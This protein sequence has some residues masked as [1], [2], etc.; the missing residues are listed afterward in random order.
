MLSQITEIFTQSMMSLLDTLK[1]ITGNYGFAIIVFAG[2]VKL[3]LYYPTQ[4]QYKS[5]KDMQKIQPM[6][7]KLQEKYKNDAQKLQLEQMALFKKYNINPLGGCLPLLIQMPILIGIFVTI[8]KMAGLGKFAQETFL[9]IGGSLSH[10]YPDFIGTNLASRDIPLLLIYAISMY[11]SQKMSVK[12]P[13][14]EGTQKMMNWIMPLVFPLM[15]SNFPSALILYWC[16]FNV[17]STVQQYLIMREP[18]APLPVIK[19]PEGE[20]SSEE[21][22]IED[23]TS[24]KRRSRSRKRKGGK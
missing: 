23:F 5:M 16:T 9:W 1:N 20:D 13:S 12:D 2:L 24:K 15:L 6:L 14:S 7:K 3:A 8:R 4:S 18:P 10:I 21:E 11:L 22:N 17:F 19:S